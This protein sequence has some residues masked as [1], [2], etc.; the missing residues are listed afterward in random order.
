M[1]LARRLTVALTAI[2]VV[3]SPAA[4]RASSDADREV[5]PKYSREAAHDVKGI[6]RNTNDAAPAARSF[7]APLPDQPSGVCDHGD[8]PAIC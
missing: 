7:I 2:F 8:N 5:V 6:Y 4:T 1:T 3:A